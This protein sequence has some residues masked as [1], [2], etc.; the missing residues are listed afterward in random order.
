[1]FCPRLAIDKF[2]VQ[3]KR[4][5]LGKSL[6]WLLKQFLKTRIDSNWVPFPAMFQVVDGDA[7]IDAIHCARRFQ[8]S[9]EERKRQ[10]FFTDASIDQR[11]IAIH[12]HAVNGIFRFR[13]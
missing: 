7:V 4:S 3:L 1:M 8:Q 9:L 2:G 10:V 6:R 13:L 11:E 12:D 5:S